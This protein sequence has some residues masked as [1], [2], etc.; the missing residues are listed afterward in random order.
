MTGRTFHNYKKYTLILLIVTIAALVICAATFSLKRDSTLA[1]QGA[2]EQ[3]YSSHYIPK[4]TASQEN[5]GRAVSGGNLPAMP[6]PS[7]SPTAS[8]RQETYLVTL[9]NGKIG[10]Y[11]EGE[12]EPQLTREIDVSQLP[13]EDLTLLE[14]GIPAKSFSEARSIL[15]D[16]E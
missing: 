3:T 16:Y 4:P 12:Q 11:L 6:R 5:G 1:V 14:Q 2:P 9:K 15:E 7:P 8:Q 10:I 13:K